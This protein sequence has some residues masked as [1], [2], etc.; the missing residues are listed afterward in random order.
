MFHV[1]CVTLKLLANT[2]KSVMFIIFVN[3]S[4]QNLKLF[5]VI[6]DFKISMKKGR[7]KCCWL[8]C[9]ICGIRYYLFCHFFSS[10]KGA[11]FFYF[12]FMANFRSILWQLSLVLEEN[13]HMKLSTEKVIFDNC[14][15]FTS[16]LPTIK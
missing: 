6:L 4:N 15:E 10:D 1:I 5:H 11:N 14:Y 16:Y 2:G 3:F 12:F 7:E 9:L 8:R 13:N